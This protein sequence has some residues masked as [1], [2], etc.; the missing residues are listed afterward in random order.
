[1]S[2][3]NLIA[4][5]PDRLP[6]TTNPWPW[7]A[8]SVALLA[9]AGVAVALILGGG[10][11]DGPA[12]PVA[13]QYRH[14]ADDVAA[15]LEPV[16]AANDSLSEE[17]GVLSPGD[18]TRNAAA[19]VRK[20]RRAAIV[21]RL[22]LLKLDLSPGTE[23]LRSRSADALVAELAYLRVV[24][25][26]LADPSTG[27]AA[28]VRRRALAARTSW[29]VVRRD[30]AGAGGRI[31]GLVAFTTWAET[32]VL[33]DGDAGSGY[34]APEPVAPEPI[35]AA[36]AD[37]MI[38]CEGYEGIYE[39]TAMGVDCS[40]ATASAMGAR[41]GASAAAANGFVCDTVPEAEPG[42]LRFECDRYDGA[43]VGFTVSN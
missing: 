16:S 28:L 23:R 14:G 42:T 33:T 34:I 37:E 32:P 35:P 20:G 6:R 29:Q 41:T 10:D 36:P 9:A 22:S 38:G 26:A 4:D 11:D 17:L 8:L 25:P 21:A 1:M 43:H 2:S 31:N 5:A 18:L 15:L 12:Q 27:R 39:I 30:I 24:G 3:H 13:T 40:E 7:I 19:A